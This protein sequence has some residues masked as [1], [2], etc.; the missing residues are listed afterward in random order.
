MVGWDTWDT[1]DRFVVVVE[2]AFA[3]VEAALLI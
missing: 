3:A 2:V 1:W